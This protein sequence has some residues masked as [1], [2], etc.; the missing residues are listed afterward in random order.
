MKER[1][2]RG[3]EARLESEPF[4]PAKIPAKRRVLYWCSSGDSNPGE[5]TAAQHASLAIRSALLRSKNAS[6]F[7]VR[8]FESNRNEKEGSSRGRSPPRIG[9]LCASKNTRQKA[10]IFT[11][12]PAGI[13]TP[14][15]LLKRQSP[16]E[17]ANPHEIWLFCVSRRRFATNLQQHAVNQQQITARNLRS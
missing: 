16:A 8:G 2:A 6:H 3:G 11:G 9:I 1:G 4:A 17:P 14:D 15:T 12:A 7:G 5:A 10:G 13:R